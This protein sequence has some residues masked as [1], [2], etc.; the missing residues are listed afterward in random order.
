MVLLLSSRR[1]EHTVSRQASWLPTIRSVTVAAQRWTC[2][3]FH[4]YALASG[5]CGSPRR[6]LHWTGACTR[7]YRCV[8]RDRRRIAFQSH[9]R[10]YYTTTQPP[11]CATNESDSASNRSEGMKIEHLIRYAPRAVGLMKI[12]NIIRYAPRAVG[13]K[14]S[15]RQGE[16]RLRGL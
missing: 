16:A 10:G 11:G 14:P 8:W 4:L 15:A 7:L 2:T 5:P 6:S 1:V 3:S 9:V 13:L 12:E